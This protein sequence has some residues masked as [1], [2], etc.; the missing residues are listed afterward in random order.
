VATAAEA[1]CS[2]ILTEGLADGT[3]LL[4]VAVLNPFAGNLLTP[5]AVA[6]LGAD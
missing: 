2:T 1:G 4:G 5:A 3:L 6:L